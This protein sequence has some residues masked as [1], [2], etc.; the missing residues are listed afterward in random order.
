MNDKTSQLNCPVC[1]N[2][3]L[4]EKKGVLTC[5]NC[6]NELELIWHNDKVVSIRRFLHHPL[7]YIKNDRS[8]MIIDLAEK[9]L[10]P[11]KWGFNKNILYPNADQQGTVIYDS[12]L[13]R[14]KLVLTSSDFFPQH[15]TTIFY[16]RLHAPDNEHTMMWN[17]KNCRCWHKDIFG[18]TLPFIEGISPQQLAENTIEI[19]DT[20]KAK[21]NIDYPSSDYVEYPLRLHSKI[22]EHY[23][24]KIFSIFDLHN[25]ELW[26][27]YSMYSNKYYEERDKKNGFRS[28]VEMIC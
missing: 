18:L 23:K 2:S 21:L 24:E 10:S 11:E 25:T 1:Q 27:E 26:E 12:K 15:D 8:Q 20:L 19:W 22:W 7:Y 14:I 17:G 3:L 5:S 13:C 4:I 28:E 9:D 16:G 6:K